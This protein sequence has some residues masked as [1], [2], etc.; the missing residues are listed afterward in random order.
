MA[1]TQR[2][3]HAA[4]TK[5]LGAEGKKFSFFQAVQLLHRLAPNAVPVGEAGP[6]RSES[7]RFVHDSSLIFHPSDITSIQMRT[8]RDGVPYVEVTSTFLGLLGSVSP[9]ATFF[10]EDVMFQDEEQALRSFYDVLHHRLVS[11]FYRA[12]KKYRFW[13]GSRADGLDPFTRRAVAFVGVEWHAMPKE[14]L[15]AQQ[16]LAMAPLLSIKSRSGRSLRMILEHVIPETGIDVTHFISRRVLLAPDQIAKI[17]TQNA[18]LGV[19]FTIGRAVTDRSGRFRVG[20]GPVNEDLFE[21]LLPGGAAFSTLR[22]IIDQFSRG[23][24][25]PEVELRLDE[26]KTINFRLGARVGSTLGVT[27]ALPTREKKPTIARFVLSDTPSVARSV[28]LDELTRSKE[29]PAVRKD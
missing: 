7:L 15:P 12:W 25:E 26:S 29:S 18:T 4:L 27:T 28:L 17:G 21:A 6:A 10:T 2:E 8:I 13:A 11:L 5:L 19:D 3:Y 22:N 23:I 24:L 9:L 20:I 14:G 1:T 16:L